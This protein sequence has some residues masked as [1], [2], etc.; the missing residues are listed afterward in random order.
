MFSRMKIKAILN[1]SQVEVK[2]LAY[3]EGSRAWEYGKTRPKGTPST[4][5]FVKTEG[6]WLDAGVV[7]I[8]SQ[9]KS[10]QWNTRHAAK[11]HRINC[12]VKGSDMDRATYKPSV[13]QLAQ[14]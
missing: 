14:A 3:Q 6:P 11:L 9:S 13:T 10:V 4:T 2:I 5:S 8:S 12:G 7:S 1:L